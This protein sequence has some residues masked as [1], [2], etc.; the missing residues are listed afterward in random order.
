MAAQSIVQRGMRWQVGNGNKVRVWRD[1]WIP[2]PCTYKV[3]TKEK[4]N[5]MN[6]LVCELINKATS[7]WNI[8]K[9][10]S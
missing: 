6:A 7:E 1:K 3:I 5:S 4:P 2:R 10:N 8:D 9:L